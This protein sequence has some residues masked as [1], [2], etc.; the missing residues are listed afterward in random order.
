MNLQ[1]YNMTLT[2]LRDPS[3][4]LGLAQSTAVQFLPV[5]EC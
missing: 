2:L 4:T 1:E 5:I 3:L